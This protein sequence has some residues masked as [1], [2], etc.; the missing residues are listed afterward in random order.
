MTQALR[1]FHLFPGLVVREVLV[2]DPTRVVN[3][4]RIALNSGSRV[5]APIQE[6]AQ[7]NSDQQHQL[8]QR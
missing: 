8:T 1:D 2:M 3:E 7:R 4:N 5:G 6:S